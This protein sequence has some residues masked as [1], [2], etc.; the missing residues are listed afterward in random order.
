[1]AAS[2]YVLTASLASDAQKADLPLQDE[3]AASPR[4]P[5]ALMSVGAAGGDGN[6]ANDLPSALWSAHADAEGGDEDTAGPLLADWDLAPPQWPGAVLPI[7][8]AA[9]PLLPSLAGDTSTHGAVPPADAVISAGG[10]R[11]LSMAGPHV[12]MPMPQTAGASQFTLASLDRTLLGTCAYV[13]PPSE[14]SEEGDAA[15]D[16]EEEEEMGPH[17]N[18]AFGEV[19]A[20]EAPPHQT[21]AGPPLQHES[22]AHSDA[23]EN[24]GEMFLSHLLPDAAFDI[25]EGVGGL[26]G[27]CGGGDAHLYLSGDLSWYEPP[28]TSM[29]H[30]ARA[31]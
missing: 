6:N 29:T 16:D 2:V 23:N 11:S 26:L 24:G 15:D 14:P 21:D 19:S 10:G 30:G 5:S 4:Q 7:P 22:L 3:G 31:S 28:E 20:A 9:L 18:C 1:M 13:P 17:A 25:S 12:M 27:G 8:L